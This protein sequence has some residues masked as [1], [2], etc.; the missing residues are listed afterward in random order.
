MDNSLNDTKTE[1]VEIETIPE[2]GVCIET[3]D[4]GPRSKPA[5][6]PEFVIKQ[7]SVLDHILEEDEDG[8]LESSYPVLGVNGVTQKSIAD[9]VMLFRMMKN[10]IIM[11]WSYNSKNDSMKKILKTVYKW[12]T[13]LGYLISTASYFGWESLQNLGDAV[14]QFRSLGSY[15]NPIKEIIFGNSDTKNEDLLNF[16]VGKLKYDKI[17][18]E[19]VSSWLSNDILN[20]FASKM[21]FSHHF[22]KSI[23]DSFEYLVNEFNFTPTF[24]TSEDNGFHRYGHLRS[25][26]YNIPECQFTNICDLFVKIASVTSLFPRDI[27]F[28]SDY[29]LFKLFWQISEEHFEKIIENIVVHKPKFTALPETMNENYRSYFDS[30]YNTNRVPEFTPPSYIIKRWLRVLTALGVEDAD[31]MNKI[32]R[33]FPRHVKHCLE[34]FT[35]H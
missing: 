6:V 19:M 33:Y 14:M 2:R 13:R 29:F 15:S 28:F 18:F 5:F 30:I 34:I 26:F 32:L 1:P 11:E 24:W 4:L 8:A 20:D 9:A 27:C 3:S 7:S 21:V 10:N 17:H 22:I 35:F 25:L 16:Y 12:R 31:I 23:V